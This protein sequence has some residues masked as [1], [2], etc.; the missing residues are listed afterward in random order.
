MNFFFCLVF[1]ELIELNFCELSKNIKKKINARAEKD[2]N[3]LNKE[4]RETE[5]LIQDNNNN[6]VFDDEVDNK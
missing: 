5:L 6:D 1:L 4:A 3:L 2:K